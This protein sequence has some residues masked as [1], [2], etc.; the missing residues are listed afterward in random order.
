MIPVIFRL[1]VKYKFDSRD[2]EYNYDDD[3]EDVKIET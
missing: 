2:I 1:L 3:F